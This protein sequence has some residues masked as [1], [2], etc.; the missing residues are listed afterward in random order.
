[1]KDDLKSR[2]V[3]KVRVPKG[4]GMLRHLV[5]VGAKLI[6]LTELHHAAV[7]APGDM[8]NFSIISDIINEKLGECGVWSSVSKGTS[9]TSCTATARRCLSGRRLL[10][11]T[12]TTTS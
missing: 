12:R 5:M 1:M 8:K 6:E 3:E 4:D 2:Y 7:Q 11:R 9:R 10:G